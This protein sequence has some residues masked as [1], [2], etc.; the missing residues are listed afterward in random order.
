MIGPLEHKGTG[1]RRA[2]GYAGGLAG[3]LKVAVR[4]LR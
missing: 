4:S 3:D 1:I 2:S